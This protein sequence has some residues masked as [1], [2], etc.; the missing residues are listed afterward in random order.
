MGII[1]Q[2]N[3]FSLPHCWAHMLLSEVHKTRSYLHGPKHKIHNFSLFQYL[4]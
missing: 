3:G 2:I 4:K 1:E